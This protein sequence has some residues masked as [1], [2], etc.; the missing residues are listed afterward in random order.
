MLCFKVQL[1]NIR[2]AFASAFHG[3]GNLPGGAVGDSAQ[4]VV[5][6]VCMNL[7]CPALLVAQLLANEVEAIAP[8]TC[9]QMLY[10]SLC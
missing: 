8:V 5:C 4:R 6:Q 2:A 9:P 1:R 3:G 7:G 10:Q